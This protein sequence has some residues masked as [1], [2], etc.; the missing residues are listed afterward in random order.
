V[1]SETFI[2][3]DDRPYGE[4]ESYRVKVGLLIFLHHERQLLEGKILVDTI[5]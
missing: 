4:R 3:Y 5:K 2:F 1:K